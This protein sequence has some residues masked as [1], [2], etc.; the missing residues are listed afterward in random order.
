MAP[1]KK[2]VLSHWSDSCSKIALISP[3]FQFLYDFICHWFLNVTLK[4]AVQENYPNSEFVRIPFQS[5][6]SEKFVDER[7]VEK[8]YQWL[9]KSLKEGNENEI[10]YRCINLALELQNLANQKSNGF[11]KALVERVFPTDGT[12]ETTAKIKTFDI[13]A[14]DDGF[15]KLEL[16]PSTL[17]V[18][19]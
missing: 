3:L 5:V 2:V 11:L 10:R 4:T 12:D 16:I 18:C 14:K 15:C 7:E 9:S 17:H 1:C 6:V 19:L 13:C 8:S